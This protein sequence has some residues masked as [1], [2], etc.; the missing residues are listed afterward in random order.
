[1]R[2]SRLVGAGLLDLLF[3]PRCVACA[4]YGNSLCAACR[5][6]IEPA[7]PIPAPAGL[8]AIA[9]VGAHRGVLRQAV[10]ELKFGARLAAVDPLGELLATVI[11]ERW[12]EWQP[13]ALVPVP[14]HWTRRLRRGFNQSELL[15]AAAA[16]RSGAA[17][18]PA[19]I[20]TRRTPPQ[21]G[22]SAEERRANVQAAFQARSALPYGRVV[23]VDD[24]CT[25][26]ATLAA[27]AAALR[28]AGAERVYGLTVTSEPIGGAA[29]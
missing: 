16:R 26:G 14:I 3:P 5:A 2:E 12:D 10:L 27:C 29:V 15:C 21:V 24:V 11:A 18:L 6:R 4:A 17:V 13:E 19:L 20:R 28:K 7:P 22:R 25:T 8:A 23:L 1:M 9:A